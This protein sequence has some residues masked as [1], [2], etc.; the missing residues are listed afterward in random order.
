MFSWFQKRLFDDRALVEAIRLAEEKTS[1]EIRVFVTRKKSVD[2][3]ADAWEHFEKLGISRTRERNGVLIFIAPSS[4]N[5]AIL[6]DTAI[7]ERCGDDFWQD[8]AS[9]LGIA[10]AAGR[11]QEGLVAAIE[12]LGNLLGREF[13][14]RPEDT[15]ELPD[16]IERD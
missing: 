8:T 15:N 2:P 7:H 4:R 1:G 3:V 6:G 12:E 9:R 11:F 13:P 16:G 10:F 5:F 14:H